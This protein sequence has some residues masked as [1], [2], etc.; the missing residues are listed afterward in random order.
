[1]LQTGKPEK[2]QATTS[3]NNIADHL[4]YDQRKQYQK[5]TLIKYYII[6]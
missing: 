1:M 2:K 4:I 3:K 5:T 6:P